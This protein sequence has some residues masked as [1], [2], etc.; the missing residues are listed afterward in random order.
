MDDLQYFSKKTQ[1]RV[2]LLLYLCLIVIVVC[3]FVSIKRDAEGFYDQEGT[4]VI[5]AVA[6]VVGSLLYL[7]FFKI[8]IKLASISDKWTLFVIIMTFPLGIWYFYP[9]IKY[10]RGDTYNDI[11]DNKVFKAT[12]RAYQKAWARQCVFQRVGI[13]LLCVAALAGIIMGIDYLQ[14]NYPDAMGWIGLI[15]FGILF[16]FTLY[17]IG[18]VR[19]VRRTYDTYTAEVGT[20]MFDYGQVKWYKT[21]SVTKDETDISLVAVIVSIALLPFE[22]MLL[23]A[24]VFLFVALQVIRMILPIGGKRTIYLHK[25]KMGIHPMYMPFSE[26]FLNVII[27][28]INRIL[29]AVLSFNF[30]NDD[31]WTDGVGPNYICSNLSRRNER[32]LEKLLEKVERKHGYYHYF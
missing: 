30:V 10:H 1:E 26:S 25:R 3:F 27:M 20:S 13:P 12:V 9:M 24:V 6:G 5:I 2:N 22:T 4:P 14:M 15:F 8:L 23:V 31:F 21:D 19:E 7:L 32:Y 28:Y 18:G 16:L 17:L 11:V 29:G